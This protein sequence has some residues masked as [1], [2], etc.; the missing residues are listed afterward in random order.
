MVLDIGAHVCVRLR[1]KD[2]HFHR[3]SAWPVSSASTRKLLEYLEL[4]VQWDALHTIKSKQNP[5]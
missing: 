4:G 2:A 3:V 1:G 5:Q